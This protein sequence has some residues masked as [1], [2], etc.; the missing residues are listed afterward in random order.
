MPAL[1]LLGLLQATQPV[2]ARGLVPVC[3]PKGTHWVEPAGAPA[4]QQPE[5][6]NP[7]LHGW[8]GARKARPVKSPG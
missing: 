5:T 2:L 3:T 6:A 7:C 1:L 4:D 8:C